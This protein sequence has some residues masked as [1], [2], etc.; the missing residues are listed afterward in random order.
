MTEVFKCRK[1]GTKCCAPKSLIRETLGQKDEEVAV[2]KITTVTPT[3]V[4]HST[5]PWM[6]LNITSTPSKF[7]FSHY[8]LFY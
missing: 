4:S 3:N 8:Q 5:P 6:L 2:P 1:M 7:S